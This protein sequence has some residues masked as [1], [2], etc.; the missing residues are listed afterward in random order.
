MRLL[1]N[2]TR[3]EN[4]TRRPPATTHHK[5]GDW[6]EALA[7]VDVVEAVDVACCPDD[8]EVVVKVN[9][10]LTGWPSLEVTRQITVYRPAGEPG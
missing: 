5:A 2:I 9:L 1:M 6:P 8:G 3:S 7:G 4:T 10:P